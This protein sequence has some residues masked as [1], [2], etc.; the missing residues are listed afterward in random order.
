MVPRRSKFEIIANILRLSEASRTKILY[1]S[2]LSWHLLD[3]YLSQLTEGGFLTIT[4]KGKH[5]IYRTTKEGKILLHKINDVCQR[6]G[7]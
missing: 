6:L 5:K 2:N 7:E 1:S 3:K 4:T